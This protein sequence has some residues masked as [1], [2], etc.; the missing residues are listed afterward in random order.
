MIAPTDVR[1]DYILAHPSF[2]KKSSQTYQGI[3]KIKSG[4]FYS[5]GYMIIKVLVPEENVKEFNDAVVANDYRILQLNMKASLRSP[6]VIATTMNLLR[7]APP[8]TNCTRVRSNDEQ[9]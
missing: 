2:G 9:P 6:P 8:P 5:A 3:K 1:Y 7:L 4:G